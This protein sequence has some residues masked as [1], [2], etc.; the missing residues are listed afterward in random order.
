MH[1]KKFVPVTLAILLA[2][3]SVPVSSMFDT[4]SIL[5]IVKAEDN[6]KIPETKT[7][8]KDSA[9]NEISQPNKGTITLIE[10]KVPERP[11]D[12][13]PYLA[14]ATLEIQS[15]QSTTFAI[16]DIEEPIIPVTEE[17]VIV[18]PNK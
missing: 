8:K 16:P 3:S 11:A 1:I 14:P 4:S 12:T 13:D 18:M 5:S 6:S 10:P 7:S 2:A 17:T 9:V 15:E